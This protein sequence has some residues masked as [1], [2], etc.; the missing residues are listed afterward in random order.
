MSSA[1]SKA[2]ISKGNPKISTDL[3]FQID[4]SMGR[5]AE[6]KSLRVAKEKEAE[7]RISSQLLKN[8]LNRPNDKACHITSSLPN[9]EKQSKSTHES[10]P[11]QLSSQSSTQKTSNFQLPEGNQH[12]YGSKLIQ[13]ALKGMKKSTS[14]HVNRADF[15]Q[16]GSMNHGIARSQNPDPTIPN[17]NRAKTDLSEKKLDKVSG[18]K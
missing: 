8:R 12:S 9:S 2:Y 17:R 3:R 15:K 5:D 10:G 13:D 14:F 16:I 7:G 18:K 11:F 1:Q 6:A 4:P